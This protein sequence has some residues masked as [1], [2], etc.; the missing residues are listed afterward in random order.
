MAPLFTSGTSG[1]CRGGEQRA[2]GRGQPDRPAIPSAFRPLLSAL[3]PLPS[4]LRSRP[5]A[6]GAAVGVLLTG[7]SLGAASAGDLAGRVTAG[8]RPVREAVLFV[9]DLKQPPVNTRE[10]MDQRRRTFIPHVMAVQ[11]GTRV[12][13]PNSDTVFHNAFSTREGK[14][15]DLGLY[16]VGSARRVVFRQPGL[17][18]IFCNI[19]SNMSAFIWV[20]E[21][22]FFAVTDRAGR[23]R[24]RGVPAGP[25][26]VRVWHERL[27]TRRVPVTS[28]PEGTETLDVSLNSP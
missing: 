2:E 20:V 24:I 14:P 13:F 9:E 16:P 6:L 10:Q 5:F 7:Y 1:V 4:A 18:R 12:D 26:V 17:I 15:F 11:V 28:S 23:F 19:H 3:R 25:R 21:N 8:G 27:G 22:S